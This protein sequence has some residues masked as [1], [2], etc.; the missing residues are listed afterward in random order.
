MDNKPITVSNE[1]INRYYSL[2][3]ADLVKESSLLYAQNQALLKENQELKNK[4]IKSN[5]A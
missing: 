2:K 3:I 1:D 4:G 5:K